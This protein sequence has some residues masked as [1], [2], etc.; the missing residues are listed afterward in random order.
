MRQRLGQEP[1]SR[2]LSR[3]SWRPTLEQ[4][5]AQ[6]DQATILN[7]GRARRLAGAAG[8]AP[9]EVFARRRACSTTFG[10]LLDQVYAAPRAVEFITGNAV[11]RTGRQ[12]EAAVNT[13][14]QQALQLPA[15]CRVVEFRVKIGVH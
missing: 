2:S 8:Q 1:A 3:P 13:V 6:I 7:A 15:L 10:H 5:P 4:F 14:T 12:A 9:I 11:G